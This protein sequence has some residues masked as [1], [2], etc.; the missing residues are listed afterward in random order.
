MDWLCSI[1]GIQFN[2][3]HWYFI[4]LSTHVCVCEHWSSFLSMYKMKARKTYRQRHLYK[5]TMYYFF[6][7]E[8]NSA[9]WFLLCCCCLV[10]RLI[11]TLLIFP[12]LIIC[13]CPSLEVFWII[14]MKMLES[15]ESSPSRNVKH[16]YF[17][18]IKLL[19]RWNSCLRRD[20]LFTLANSV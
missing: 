4:A 9:I 13:E 5:I 10:I 1:D 17:I 7:D 18:V 3:H 8:S 14:H 11:C 12:L 20:H 16:Q 6:L 2:Q 19:S 15:N